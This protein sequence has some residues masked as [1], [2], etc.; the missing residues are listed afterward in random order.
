MDE[1]DLKVQAYIS[2]SDKDEE[3][4]LTTEEIRDNLIREINETQ[5]GW[6]QNTVGFSL[7]EMRFG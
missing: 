7:N 3:K 6:K 2:G 5:S 1:L 4:E